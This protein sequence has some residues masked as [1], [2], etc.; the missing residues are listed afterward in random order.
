MIIHAS[1]QSKE[2]I[3]VTFP[4]LTQPLLIDSA[5]LVFGKLFIPKTKVRINAL[6]QR[7]YSPCGFDS[8]LLSQPL[9]I[10]SSF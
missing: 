5:Q 1:S 3:F 7:S 8:S 4:I 6:S 2:F 9:W 10:S